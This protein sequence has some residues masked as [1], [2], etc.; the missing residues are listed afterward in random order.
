M[1][2]VTVEEMRALEEASASA[3]TSTD[4][5]MENAG[6]A[7]AR[8]SR[9]AAGGAAGVRV[10]V[11]VGPGNNGGDG[12]VAARHLRRWGA[13]VT[14]YLVRPRPSDDTPLHEAAHAD[15][16]ILDAADDPESHLLAT[17]LRRARVVLDAVLGTGRARP[18]EGKVRE[19]MLATTAARAAS[20]RMIVVALDVPTGM[21]A[22]TGAVDPACPR[23]DVTVTFGF[24]KRGHFQ[25]P[26]AAHV[27][28]LEVVDVGIAGE[29]SRQIDLELLT[30]EWVRDRLPSRPPQSHKGT[31][32]HALIVAGSPNY[33]GAAYLA[34]Q[35]AARVGPGL[36]TLASPE[37]IYPI[38]ASKLTEVIHLPLPQ[39]EDGRIQPSAAGVIKENLARYS[40]IVAGC[41]FGRSPGLVELLRGLLL[42]EP[43]PEVPVVIDADGLN[44][45]AQIPE[46]W[47]GVR[48]PLVVTPHPGE[49][50]TLTSVPTP[51]VQSRR[52]DVARE[53]AAKW[54]AVVALKGAHTVVASPDGACRV[55]PFANPG[56]SSGG[57]GDVLTGVIGGLLAQGLSPEHATCCGVYV[58]GL[59]GE[60]AKERL[61][62]TG[63][64]AG[65]LLSLL[66]TAVRDIRRVGPAR[67]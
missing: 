39:D 50:T 63:M 59:A 17:D 65:D 27:G 56:L 35:A 9:Q 62:E 33:I 19:T 44:N 24:P 47:K 48:F 28:R 7:V 45:L 4:T 1:K 67:A 37:G 46:W 10:L 22:D 3:G 34:A 18:L 11:L 13:E 21:D 36:V 31:F 40:S 52:L 61:G 49:M 51:D 25:F 8:L 16:A 58:H 12:L 38:L 57:T 20:P 66:P 26:G 43:P 2:I 6:L 41:G 30:A 54:N 42:E 23:S 29:L 64:L 32:G 55:S 53:Y 15:V 5:L 14:A 60:M